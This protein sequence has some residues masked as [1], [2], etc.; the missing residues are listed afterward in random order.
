MQKNFFSYSLSKGKTELQPNQ[1][2][3]SKNFTIHFGNDYSGYSEKGT[4]DYP[5]KITKAKDKKEFIN[6]VLES[7]E[8]K[9]QNRNKYQRQYRKQRAKKKKEELEKPIPEVEFFEI[10]KKEKKKKRIP[11]I[12]E[13][14]DKVK[15]LSKKN[16]ILWAIQK[17]FPSQWQ[18]L[19]TKPKNFDPKAFRITSITFPNN[20]VKI[21]IKRDLQSFTVK[22]QNE[23][24]A[25]NVFQSYLFF[26]EEIEV[27]PESEEEGFQKQLIIDYSQTLIDHIWRIKG[28][29]RYI[30]KLFTP[31][32]DNNDELFLGTENKYSMGFSLARTDELTMK[33]SLESMIWNT[34]EQFY[35]D[36]VASA[37]SYLSRKFM[38]RITMNGCMIEKVIDTKKQ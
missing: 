33:S 5:S 25:L 7:L 3:L 28:D 9:R 21:H 18:L 24:I 36:G 38:S 8:S 23:A 16:Q 37:K 15:K 20:M 32:Y 31:Q 30:F 13:N 6:N 19:M 35:G 26:N 10:P 27:T 1:F 17:Y 2:Y 4:F 14:L 11:L 12:E 29:H 34:L 22:S